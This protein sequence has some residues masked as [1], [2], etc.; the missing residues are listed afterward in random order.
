MNPFPISLSLVL[1]LVSGGA[2]ARIYRN[3][4]VI[5]EFRKIHPCPYAKSDC[6]ADHVV[7]L[8]AGGAD[9]VS[10]LQWQ[11]KAES[12]LKDREER[13]VCAEERKRLGR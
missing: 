4:A 2:E 5:R 7:P 8:C 1:M 3:P 11:H 6:I 9:A 12:L 13:R 10:N